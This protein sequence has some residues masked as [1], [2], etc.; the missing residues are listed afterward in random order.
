MYDYVDAD[1]SSYYEPERY[2]TLPG[3]YFQFRPITNGTLDTE[4]ED[5]VTNNFYIAP[6]SAFP[7]FVSGN[8]HRDFFTNKLE[9]HID[10][11]HA[12][13]DSIV[14]RFFST[15]KNPSTG[16]SSIIRKDVTFVVGEGPAH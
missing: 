13:G 11:A 9:L 1:Y 12:I 10:E 7:T 5:Y 4:D 3:N 2:G 6:G 14:I 15:Y 8:L 16:D